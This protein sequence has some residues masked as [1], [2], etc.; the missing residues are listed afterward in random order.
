M[1]NFE[2]TLATYHAFNALSGIYEKQKSAKLL[3]ASTSEEIQAIFKENDDH[4]QEQEKRYK[5]LGEE[6][7]S[8][9]DKKWWQVWK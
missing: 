7:V 5:E 4:W 8:I 2:E 3:E 9:L 6:M 1:R